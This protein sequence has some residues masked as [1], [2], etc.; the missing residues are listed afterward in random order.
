MK[1]IR[2]LI[3]GMIVCGGLIVGL[4]LLH[5]QETAMPFQSATPDSIVQITAD[6]QGLEL[7]P[8]DQ[9]PRSGTFWLFMPGGIAAPAP[10]PPLDSSLPI[11]VIANQQF[12]VDETGGQ[13]AMNTRRFG[14]QAQAASSTGLSA[15]ELQANTV[16]NLITRVQTT[17]ANQQM[18]TMSRSMGMD[19]PGFDDIG[20]GGGGTNDFYSD[21]F[22]Y[23]VPTN[24]LWL[25]I[26]NVANGSA[27]LNLRGATNFV[28]EIYS[29]TNL[30]EP[31][32]DIASE[33]FPSDTN[34]MPFALSLAPSPSL[35][36]VWAR[37]WTGVTSGG[38][39]VPEWWF[40]KYFGTV[41][42]ADTNLD[43]NGATLLYDYT[44][45]IDPKHI[46][47]TPAWTNMVAHVAAGDIP[48]A[49]SSFASD[50]ADKYQQA[51]IS[52]GT[53][54]VISAMNQI[55]TLTPAFV[56]SD[57]AEYYFTNTIDGQVITFPVEFVKENG[58]W[59]I[60]EF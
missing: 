31:A 47:P 27:F 35:M 34:C 57:T 44:N 23:H 16:L 48:G 58:V 11:Y 51:F 29:K 42:L 26:T 22:N 13:V 59:K 6:A 1:A 12:L 54:D 56:G 41:A 3:V 21:S 38:N 52:I 8:P 15:L 18:R 24:G 9:A 25:E 53:N 55:G 40:W 5:G 39:T 7:V 20:G 45:G 10:C 46:D 43:V 60:L 30:L 49:V 32:W 2:N 50:T 4:H 36:F 28:Y 37:D 19:V 33:V 17:A 14:L